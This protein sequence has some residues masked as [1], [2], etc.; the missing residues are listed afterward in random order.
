MVVQ[1]HIENAIWH[2]LMHQEIRGELKIKFNKLEPQRLVISIEDNGIGREAAS[3][4]RNKQLY[5][6]KSFGSSLSEQKLKSL[7]FL[8]NLD[9]SLEILDLKDEACNAKGTKVNIS[10]PIITQEKYGSL[11]SQ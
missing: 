10:M 11:K 7:S 3:L 8:N 1:P 5:K 6:K 2:G 4:L 9:Y